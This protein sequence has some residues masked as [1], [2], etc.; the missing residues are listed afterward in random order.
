MKETNQL[1]VFKLKKELY[2]IPITQVKEIIKM[3][4]ISKLPEMPRYIPGIINLRGKIHVIYDLRAR[5]GLEGKDTN[6]DTKIIVIS[7]K[8]L[9]FIVDEVN[10]ISKIE[11]EDIYTIADL[12]V[13]FNKKY[14]SNIVK[15]NDDIII[16][17]NLNEILSSQ[18]KNT[19][20][21]LIR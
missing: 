9:G 16:I 8:N 21:T 11:Q 19:V 3:T 12:P 5:F 10:A 7:E 2:G 17:L 13:D 1:V 4:Q 14:I 20:K 6:M 15:H 18:E